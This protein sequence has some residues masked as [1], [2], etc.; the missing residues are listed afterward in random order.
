MKKVFVVLSFILSSF[1]AFAQQDLTLSQQFISRINKNPAG[2]GNICDIDAFLLGRYQWIDME[3][4]PKSG[5]LN[6]QT[7]NERLSSG[8]GFTMSYDDLGVA[9]RMFNPKLVYAYDMKLRDDMILALGLS[10]GIQYGYFDAAQYTLEDETEVDDGDFPDDKQ[11]KVSPDFDFGAEFITPRIL[12]GFS[13][14]HITASEA[15]TLQADR[16]YYLYG[17]YIFTLNDKWD[18]APGLTWMHKNEVNVTELNC[19]AYYGRLF[20]GGLTYHPDLNDTFGTNPL[21]VTL[22]FEYENFRIGYTFDYN[23]GK[24]A[25]YSKTAHE[26]MLSYSFRSKHAAPNYDRFE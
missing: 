22:G 18:L 16:H 4:S 2:V 23:F 11:T 17:R 20:W 3:D 10:A 19:T 8:F 12:V 13:V 26:L 21:A 15:T 9:K 6:I 14:T 5:V 25:H 24:V 1:A 7:Y